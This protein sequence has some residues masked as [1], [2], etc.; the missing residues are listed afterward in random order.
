[1]EKEVDE[2]KRKKETNFIDS[3]GYT[4]FGTPVTGTGS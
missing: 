2:Y 3:F 4:P 1:M